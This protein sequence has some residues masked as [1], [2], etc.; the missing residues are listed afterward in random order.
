MPKNIYRH[1]HQWVFKRLQSDNMGHKWSH[2]AQHQHVTGHWAGLYSAM[3]SYKRLSNVNI[4]NKIDS[5]EK[6]AHVKANKKLWKQSTVLELS[7][8]IYRSKNLQLLT[9]TFIK[10]NMKASHSQLKKHATTVNKNS[11]APQGKSNS[12]RLILTS[13]VNNGYWVEKCDLFECSNTSRY[14]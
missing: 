13:Q 10:S 4:N 1:C 11:N 2:T 14:A 5:W 9:L 3:M 12:P 8:P 7:S 6:Q